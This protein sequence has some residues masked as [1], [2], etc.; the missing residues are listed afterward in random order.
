MSATHSVRTLLN[1]EK[2]RHRDTR[3]RATH[4]PTPPEPASMTRCVLA[5]NHDGSH[6]GVQLRMTSVAFTWREW[7]RD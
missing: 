6:A 5:K 7:A 3:C 4:T 1:F 2:Y